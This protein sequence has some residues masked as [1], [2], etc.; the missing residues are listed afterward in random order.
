M[1]RFAILLAAFALAACGQPQQEAYPSFYEYNFMQACRPTE[2][3]PGLC[4]CVW[5]RVVA[6]VPRADFEAFERLPEA[7][8]ASNPLTQQIQSF[9]MQC[10]PEEMRPQ[11]AQQP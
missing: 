5:G 10:A 11:P 2:P 7:E 9:A 4:Q 3:L 8:R 6:E 1:S